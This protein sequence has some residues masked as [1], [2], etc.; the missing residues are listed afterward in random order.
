MR[1]LPLLLGL[2]LVLPHAVYAQTK[3]AAG[4]IPSTDILPLFVGVQEGIFQRHG[5]DVTPTPE[6]YATNGPA[7]LIAGSIQVAMSTTPIFSQAREGGLDLVAICGLSWENRS[8]PQLSMLVRAGSDIKTAKDLEGHKV[9]VPGLNSLFDITA[10]KWIDESGGDHKKVTFVEVPMPQ[11]ADVLRGG[12]VDA[13]AV[14]DPFRARALA[15][16]ATRLA[17]YLADIKDNQPLAFW[18]AQRDWA[19]AHRD[20]IPAWRDSM[21]E[22]M[23][24]IAAHPDEARALGSKYLHGQV[25]Q[26]FANWSTAMSPDDLALEVQI[27]QQEGYMQQPFD[28]QAAVFK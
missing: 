20:A 13:I 25:I 4:Y 23:E 9:A 21:K 7:A 17:N 11:L 2:L 22:A 10:T 27:A 5:L 14:I 6:Q 18:I 1:L 28:T 15:N 24:W 3:I 12:S 19:E 26:N 8:N 16:G